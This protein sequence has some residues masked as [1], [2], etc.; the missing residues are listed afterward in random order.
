METAPFGAVKD[1]GYD[2]QGLQR[3][4]WMVAALLAIL[5]L[6]RAGLMLAKRWQSFWVLK[7]ASAAMDI[8]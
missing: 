7:Q 2:W 8:S 6:A 4:N 1:H 5:A 3:A